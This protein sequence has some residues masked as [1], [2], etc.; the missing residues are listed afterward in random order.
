MRISFLRKH[1]LFL[2]ATF[3]LM[4]YWINKRESG[5]GEAIYAQIYLWNFNDFWSRGFVDLVIMSP[6]NIFCFVVEFFWELSLTVFFFIYICQVSYI[7]WCGCYKCPYNI[8]DPCGSWLQTDMGQISSELALF[9]L[10]M[11]SRWLWCEYTN[12]FDFVFLPFLVY[13]WS[14]SEEPFFV[15]Y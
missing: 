15:S 1:L 8:C 4:L 6:L 7:S 5:E 2:V 12:V 10:L 3:L 14:S 11:H 9:F 13:E